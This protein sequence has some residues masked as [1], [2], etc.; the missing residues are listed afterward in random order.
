MEVVSLSKQQP[1][2]SRRRRARSEFSNLKP[3][4]SKKGTAFAFFLGKD[5]KDG[6]DR[7]S[8]PVRR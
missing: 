7:R 3:M 5:K 2:H 1:R 8:S 4:P 6:E